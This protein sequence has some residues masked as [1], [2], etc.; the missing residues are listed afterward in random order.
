MDVE[1]IVK[2]KFLEDSNMTFQQVFDF[3]FKIMQE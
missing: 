3:A 1:T 2:P